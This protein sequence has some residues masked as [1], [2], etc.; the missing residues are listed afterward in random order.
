[1]KLFAHEVGGEFCVGSLYGVD[2]PVDAL[3]HTLR[4]GER[5]HTQRPGGTECY[6][7]AF[8]IP[9]LIHYARSQ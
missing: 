2:L 6:C 7:E 5:L 1:M 8:L 4:G 9:P 3:A